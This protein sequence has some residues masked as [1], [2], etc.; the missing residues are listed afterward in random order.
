MT[1]NGEQVKAARKLLR[2]SQAKLAKKSRVTGGRIMD[3]ES[4]QA[5]LA[6]DAAD[7]VQRALESGGIQF[8]S[9]VRPGVKLRKP[10]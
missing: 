5:T 10:E 4:G 1:I 3:C 9:D 8:T 2:W 7:A 6:P